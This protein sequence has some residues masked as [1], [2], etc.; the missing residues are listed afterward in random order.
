MSGYVWVCLGMSG[1]VWV[2]LGRL[3]MVTMLH[4]KRV[5]MPYSFQHLYLPALWNYGFWFD[6][7]TNDQLNVPTTKTLQT[8]SHRSRAPSLHSRRQSWHDA[9]RKSGAQEAPRRAHR[10][11]GRGPSPGR[12]KLL[13]SH[14]KTMRCQLLEDEMWFLEFDMN[15]IM[16]AFFGSPEIERKRQ[17]DL[18]L[19]DLKNLWNWWPPRVLS[20]HQNTKKIISM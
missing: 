3:F 6:Q 9:P 19:D 18:S 17:L 1:Y 12:L 20:F 14:G 15:E 2:C 8:S 13:K 5:A 4:P 10:G 7:N 11:R 16:V